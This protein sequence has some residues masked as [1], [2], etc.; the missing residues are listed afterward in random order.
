VLRDQR[1]QKH[2]LYHGEVIADAGPR[3]GSEGEKRQMVIVGCT[4]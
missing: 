4:V 3:S 1:Q 2:T